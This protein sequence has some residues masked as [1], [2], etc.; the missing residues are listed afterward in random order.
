ME[1]LK[2]S[3]GI[4]WNPYYCLLKIVLNCLELAEAIST[5]CTHRAGSDLCR[6]N[7]VCVFCGIGGRLRHG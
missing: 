6:L 7:L 1:Y 4:R 5:R 3:D 2:N